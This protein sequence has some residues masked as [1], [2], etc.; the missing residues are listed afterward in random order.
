[1]P[2]YEFRCRKCGRKNE[3]ITFRISEPLSPSCRYCGSNDLSRLV[4]RVRVR[5][6]EETRFER[7]ADPARW[8]NIDENDPR[9][10]ARALKT[11]GQEIG[12]DLETDIDELVEES[13]EEGLSETE[14]AGG[15]EEQNASDPV[16]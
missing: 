13:L 9:S 11:M 14:Q 1:M 8:G 5:L 15:E 7:L 3:F 2:I 4:S 10:L 16:S 6:S 12:D